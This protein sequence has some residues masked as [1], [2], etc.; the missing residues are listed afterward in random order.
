MADT[1]P[2]TAVIL[3]GWAHLNTSLSQTLPTQL[4]KAHRTRRAAVVLLRKGK[5]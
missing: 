4:F 1:P 5:A 2:K 3:K